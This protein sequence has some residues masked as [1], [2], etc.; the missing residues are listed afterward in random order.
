MRINY[1]GATSA[2]ENKPRKEKEGVDTWIDRYIFK[3][4]TDS[5]QDV[6]KLLYNLTK[7]H[8]VSEWEREWAG[9]RISW[10]SV[11]AAGALWITDNH[12]FIDGG[13]EQNH[14]LNLP[15]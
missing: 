10:A 2:K 11:D 4:G 8:V 1:I 13:S 6:C 5:K 14:E 12:C 3:V 9:L 7:Q 15:K